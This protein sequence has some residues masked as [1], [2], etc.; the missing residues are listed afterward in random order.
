MAT[1]PHPLV[2]DFCRESGNVGALGGVVHYL[3]EAGQSLYLNDSGLATQVV[4]VPEGHWESSEWLEEIQITDYDDFNFLRFDHPSNGILYGIAADDGE[5]TFLRYIYGMDVSH[6]VDSWSWLTQNDSPIAQFDSA[7]QNIDPEIF[8]DDTSLFQ[9]G[10]KIKVHIFMGDSSAYPIGLVWLDESGYD[11]GASTIKMSG[12]NTIGYYLKDQTFDDTTKFSGTTT[13]VITAILQLAGLENFLVQVLDT[14]KEFEFK[15]SDTLLSGIETILDFYTTVDKKMEIVELTNGT[16]CVGFEDWISSHLPRN[17]Y[18]FDEGREVFK[19]NTMRAAD[20]AH[21]KVRVTGKDS[22][23]NELKPV[24]VAVNNFPYWSLGKQRTKH[25]TAPDGMTQDGLQKWAEAQAKVL[26]YIGIAEDFT[27]PFRPQLVVGDIA[28][29][30]RGDTGTSLGII[31]Q[32]KQIFDKTSGY[33]TEF[34]VDSG[35]VATD[36][37]SYTIYSRS[38]KANGYNR[39]QSI[40]D[41]V[42]YTAEKIGKV[43]SLTPS[44]VGA[45]KKGT[46]SNL[47]S[48]HNESTLAHPDIRALSSA[49]VHDLV[50]LG[51]SALPTDGTEVTLSVDTTAIRSDLNTKPVKLK[52]QISSDST[53]EVTAMVTP[54]YF[55]SANAYR[56]VFLTTHNDSLMRIRFEFT[57]T[58]IIASCTTVE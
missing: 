10:A 53:L 32:V 21:T 52:F 13:E 7:L 17:Y 3:D 34:S 4:A 28:E 50:S 15:A 46:S 39:K 12:R 24:S 31:T 27:G 42:K 57:S 16:I 51:L 14:E 8:G 44:D 6:I 58:S 11:Q 1:T 45:E 23:G 26:Q 36:G 19:R 2:W 40:V 48:A 37:E 22:D 35:G 43:D 25:L 20:G 47:L 38:A 49:P 29:V 5:I 54:V 30:V 41:L 9:P 56:V 18:S 55:T 33:I